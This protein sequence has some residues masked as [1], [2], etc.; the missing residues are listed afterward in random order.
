MG[1]PLRTPGRSGAGRSAR[2]RSIVADA[3]TSGPVVGLGL[4]GLGRPRPARSRRRL[5]R[6]RPSGVGAASVAGASALG[7]G[8]ASGPRPWAS[9][10][11]ASRPCGVVLR[12]SGGPAAGVASGRRGVGGRG[13]S[14]ARLGSGAGSGAAGCRTGPGRRPS[15]RR[16]CSTGRGSCR[17]PRSWPP[18]RPP[19][20]RLRSVPACRCPLLARRG[21]CRHHAAMPPASSEHHHPAAEAGHAARRHHRPRII[22]RHRR[23]AYSP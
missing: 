15:P 7:V 19:R 14:A 20:L 17:P 9:V 22:P 1:T 11:S 2:R 10:G 13:G 6:F 16:C 23:P 8:R 12:P 21:P 3:T 18:S 5:G 4:V